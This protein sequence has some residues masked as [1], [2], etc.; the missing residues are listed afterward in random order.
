[1]E[2]P[3]Y[4]LKEPNLLPPSLFLHLHL[5]RLLFRI[6]RQII[7]TSYPTRTGQGH[8]T[9]EVVLTVPFLRRTRRRT[10]ITTCQIV[11]FTL[12]HLNR[13]QC[14]TRTTIALTTLTGN[15]A[16]LSTPTLHI[17]HLLNLCLM[18]DRTLGSR[19]VQNVGV[20]G[21]TSEECLM[22]G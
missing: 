1:M 21:V 8:R 10:R 12:Q 3:D 19:L 2:F 9:K 22:E 20:V 16:L 15:E 4:Q 13:L 17:L 14:S 11:L 18:G 7:P 5:H 6:H